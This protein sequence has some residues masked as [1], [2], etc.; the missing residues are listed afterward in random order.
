MWLPKH[1]G[2]A[3]ASVGWALPPKKDDGDHADSLC[4]PGLVGKDSE[5]D[6]ACAALGAQRHRAGLSFSSSADVK[7]DIRR[8]YP[9]LLGVG[10]T[11]SL[12]RDSGLP[13]KGASLGGGF[14]QDRE[15]WNDDVQ[16]QSLI[17]IMIRGSWTAE[18]G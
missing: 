12:C 2:M 5:T 1:N 8:A 15:G 17:S 3:E 10:G 6:G 16:K 9:R 7:K 14:I 18:R 11:A 13:D 4:G